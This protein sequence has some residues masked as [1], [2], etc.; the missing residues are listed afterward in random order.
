MHAH[1]NCLKSNFSGQPR[2]TRSPDDN[3]ERRPITIELNLNAVTLCDGERQP[4]PPNLRH[5]LAPKPLLRS[6][7]PAGNAEWS[8]PLNI[9][10]STLSLV[11]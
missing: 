4:S 5:P 10:T 7:P 2:N 11:K 8:P 3:Q 6:A 1:V 9:P